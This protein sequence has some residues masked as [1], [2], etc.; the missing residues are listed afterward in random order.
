M[1][2]TQFS[3][4]AADLAPFVGYEVSPLSEVIAAGQAETCLT[5]SDPK[6]ADLW[7]LYGVQPSGQVT[8]LF[9]ANEECEIV[10]ALGAA[11]AVSALPITYAD[12][13]RRLESG[14][15]FGA[16]LDVLTGAILDDIG[17][18]QIPGRTRLD[19][20]DEHPMTPIRELLIR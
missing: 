3:P 8:A 20:F 10:S 2:A 5:V 9:D 4:L 6:C 15:S 11:L 7:T 16:L 13:D 19:D 18:D 1:N 17:A 12:E 14:P